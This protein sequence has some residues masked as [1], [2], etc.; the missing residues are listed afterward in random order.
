VALLAT[1]AAAVLTLAVTPLLHAS[2]TPLFFAAVTV[3]AWL[4]RVRHGIFAAVLSALILNDFL[5]PPLGHLSFDSASLLRTAMWL[6]VSCGIAFLVG[7]LR[8]SQEQIFAILNG[9]TDG[10]LSVDRD[11]KC[12]YVNQQGAELLGTTPEMMLGKPL[13]ELFP[14]GRGCNLSEKCRQAMEQ[15]QKVRYEQYYGPRDA[16]YEVTAFPAKSGMRMVFRDISDRHRSEAERTKTEEIL[17]SLPEGFAIVDRNWRVLYVN[18]RGAELTGKSREEITGKN[19]WQV[20]PKILGTPAEKAYRSCMEQRVPAHFEFPFPQRGQYFEVR[21][22]PIPEGISI[23]YQEVSQ[24]REREAQLRSALDRLA[25]AHNAANMGTWD[26]NIHTGE[27][28]WSENI[29][30]IHG[31]NP[32]QFDGTLET[33]LKT[34]HPDDLP[35]VQANIQKAIEERSDYYVEFRTIWADGKEHWVSGQGKVIPGADGQPERM[36]GIGADIDRRRREEEALRRSEKLAAAGRLAATIAHEINNPLEAVTNLVYLMR[37]DTS[38]SAETQELLAMAEEQLARVNHIARQTLAFYRERS[39]PEMVD[40]AQTFEEL[41]AILQSRLTS[42]Q[43]TVEKQFDPVQPLRAFRGEIRQVLSNLLTN[44]ID[45]SSLHSKLILRVKPGPALNN[46]HPETILMEVEDFGHGIRLEDRERIFE[47]FFTTKSD[48]GTGLGLWVS[49]QIVEKHGG[50]L[51]FRTCL[52]EGAMG[53]CFSVVL[54]A[55]ATE[56]VSSASMQVAS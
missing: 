32:E 20:F 22:F 47:P 9:I 17:S 49:R 3:S 43:V 28:N 35:M 31:I 42:K 8:E 51:E 46:G 55:I 18:Q 13:P 6:L 29:A 26:W 41:L 30:P 19:G 50:R 24:A 48:V 15:Q 4:G 45:A 12:T 38:V 23:V 53:T 40:V 25:I 5:T 39:V 11:W 16:W 2:P 1:A 36:V 34:I 37:Q 54:P 7:K 56:E 14:A 27:L 44:A 21:A 52:E 10:F 33:W